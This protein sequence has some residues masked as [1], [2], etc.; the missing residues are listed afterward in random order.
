VI[1]IKIEKNDHQLFIRV[2]DNGPL[3][4]DELIFG[5]GLQNI[6]D[7]LTLVYKDNYTI[8]FVNESEKHIEIGILE[9]RIKN[10]EVEI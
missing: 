7:K 1:K 9:V 5:Y 3:F 2:F 6:F 10:K 8:R 4:T